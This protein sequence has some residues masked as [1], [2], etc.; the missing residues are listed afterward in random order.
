MNIGQSTG[1]YGINVGGAQEISSGFDLQGTVKGQVTNTSNTYQREVVSP[2]G[3]PFSA[4]A[5]INIEG[6]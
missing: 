3:D 1:G 4:N 6:E 5:T 2:L